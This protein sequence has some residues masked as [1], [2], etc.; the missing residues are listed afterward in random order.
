MRPSIFLLALLAVAFTTPLSADIVTPVRMVEFSPASGAAGQ[1]HYNGAGTLSFDQSIRVD[2]ALG[3][4][5]DGLVGAQMYLPTFEI[6][7]I[8]SAPYMLRP[9]ANGQ[10]TIKSADNRT[11][12]LTATLGQGDLATM[13]TIAGGYTQFHADITNLSLTHEG[14]VLGSAALAV[15]SKMRNP[16]LDFELALQ[17]GSGPGYV[18]FASMLD[19]SHS[20]RGGFSG[21]MSVPEPTTVI[22]LGLGGLALLRRRTSP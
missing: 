10:I 20:G 22:L 7:G 11:T 13:G 5:G 17:G 15:L 1:W 16:S 9:L 6:G 2:S 8:P 18:S 12:Y 21:A 3:S 4:N 14:T 19:G